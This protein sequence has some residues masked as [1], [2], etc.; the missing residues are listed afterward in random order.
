MTKV[1]L[2]AFKYHSTAVPPPCPLHFQH[3]NNSLVPLP[4]SIFTTTT[5]T[6]PPTKDHFKISKNDGVQEE[7]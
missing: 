5:S 7:E 4:S 6:I 1:T 3:T 2:T